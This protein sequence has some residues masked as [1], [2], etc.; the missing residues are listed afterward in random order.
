MFNFQNLKN[1]STKQK[2]DTE[3]SLVRERIRKLEQ[4]IERLKKDNQDLEDREHAARDDLKQQANRNH[5]L[6]KELEEARAEIDAL[7]SEWTSRF[8]YF[9]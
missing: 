1:Y 7:R 8:F 3:L 9:F 4:E 6:T 5:L 2:G